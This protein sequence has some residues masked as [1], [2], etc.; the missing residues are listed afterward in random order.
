MTPQ[1]IIESIKLIISGQAEAE[2]TVNHSFFEKKRAA[3]LS[4]LAMIQPSVKGTDSIALNGY[5]DTAVKEYISV[6]PIDMDPSMSLTK[7]EF[8]TWLTEERKAKLSTK[9][10][11]RYI[12]WLGKEGRS[13]QVTDEISRSSEAILSKLSDPASSEAVY[14]RGLIVGSVQSG[15]TSNFNAVI[16]RSVD[17]GYNLVIIL[18]GIMEDLRSQTQLRLEMEVIGEGVTNIQTDSSGP[19]GVGNISRFGVQGNSETPQVFSITSHKSDFKKQ[20]QDANF[21]LNHKNLLVCKKNTGVLKNLLIWLSDYLSENEDQH[22][23]PLL[24]IDDEA[25]NA[26]LNNLGHKGREYAS[27]INGHIRA[28]LELFSRKTY[29]GYT[30]TPFANVLQ[31]RNEKAEGLWTINYKRNGE[32]VQ[33][34]LRQVDHI[35]PDDFIELLEP[36]SNYIGAKQIFETVTDPD[37][38]KIP[39]LE[40]VTDTFECFPDRLLDSPEGIRLATSKEKESNSAGIRSARKDDPFPMRIPESLKEAIECFVLAI[41]VRLKRKSSM[42][43]SRL[44]NAHNTMLIHVSRFTDWQNRTRELVQ[45]EVDRLIQRTQELPTSPDSIYAQLEKTWNQYYASIVENIRTYLPDGYADEFLQ[46]VSFEDIKSLLPAAVDGIEVK[47]IN[48][49]TKEKLVYSIDSSGNGKKYIAIGGNRLSR[50]FTLEGLTINYFIR[51]TNYADTLLQMGRWFGYRPGYIDCCKLFTTRDAIEKF[52]AATRTIEELEVEFR[53]MHR[54]GKTPEDFILRVRTH[55]GVLEITRP[56]IMKNTEEVNWSYQDTLVQ[57]TQ[58]EMNAVRISDAWTGL[59]QL[60]HR[61]K[62]SFKE[63]DGFYIMDT[64]IKG[65]FYFMD[66][67]NTFYKFSDQL[68]H[69]KDFI[70]ICEKQGKLKNWR[71]AI[72]KEGAS[73]YSIGAEESNLPGDVHLTVRSGPSEK[74]G[75]YLKEFLTNGIFTGSGR[76]AN[77]VTAG[78]DIS[79]WLDER[80]IADANKNFVLFKT[81]ELRK[82]FPN[83]SMEEA[84]KKAKDATKPERIYREKMADNNGLLVIYLMDL[85]RVFNV[86]E[87]HKRLRDNKQIDETVPLIG[88]A[89]GFPPMSAYIGGTYVKGKYEIKEEDE[90]ETEDYDEEIL[91]T[92]EEAV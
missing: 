62:S 64:D 35:F 28:I 80:E 7:K 61:N 70:T 20:V 89:I 17:A 47:A 21:S 4:L 74:S 67:P 38:K 81:E 41:A 57:T 44:Y 51:D 15:K 53:K 37:I 36:P 55:P 1:E 26:S 49:V 84:E 66:S 43:G 18:S 31:D 34:N 29:L 3:I 77:I 69:I 22:N 27:T 50:G 2:A 59:K 78:R 9:Y 5:Y 10:I 88:Y 32:I 24:I 71:I 11:D 42:A 58:F 12:T 85:R 52:N 13:K 19:K 14:T 73:E 65:L 82:K 54:A 68:R 30:A 75:N 39:L 76:S 8:Q 83:M 86:T 6:Y 48:S 79:L 91:N 23:I 72:K 25:D 40:S 33:K 60:I 16:N 63:V 92:A 46:P 56:S 90:P 45:A 87:E